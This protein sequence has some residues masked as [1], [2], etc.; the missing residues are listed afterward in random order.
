MTLDA[1]YV[2]AGA[3][4]AGLSLAWHLI[5]R[6][7]VGKRVLLID[8]RERYER[9]RAFSFWNV[10]RHPFEPHVTQRWRRWRVRAREGA[11][12]IERSAPGVEYQHL[13]ADVF[14]AAA[15]ERIERAPGVELRLGVS[16]LEIHDEGDHVRVET[17]RGVLRAR[18]V[19]DGR[20]PRVRAVA[21]PGREITLLQHFEGWIVRTDEA[22]FDA[23]TATLMDFA[24][25]QEHGIHFFYVLPLAAD[26]ALVEDTYF[27]LAT[28]P[29]SEHA[30]AI[31]RYL[32]ESLGVSRYELEARERG[33]I[34]MTTEPLP[35]RTSPRVYRIG[36]AGGLAKPSTGYA[37][38]AIQR[39][40]RAFAESLNRYTLP[41]PPEPRA[42]HVR[43]LDRIF[44]SHL[45][46]APRAAPGAICGL[47]ETLDPV[48]LARF[49]SDEASTAECLQAMR[50]M[51]VAPLGIETF[52]TPRLWLRR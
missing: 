43:A 15:L 40:S 6:G 27:G 14:Y 9:D 1:D 33:V 34:P 32:R 17:D 28:L 46:R 21:R 44:L 25:S 37:F 29:P 48:V 7:L 35:I 41:E 30:S 20:P 49:L 18:V 26:R 38:Q 45:A 3:G 52:R 12:W 13:P 24:V 2:F 10:V 19:F 5:E 22:C 31:E 4:C 51:P 50:A 36:L 42:W 39:F 47:F 8:P 11:R 16:A 23:S